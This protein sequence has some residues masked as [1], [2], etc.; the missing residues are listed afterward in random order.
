[1]IPE[2][3]LVGYFMVWRS[4]DYLLNPWGKIELVDLRNTTIEAGFTSDEQKK[5]QAIL[6]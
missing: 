6:I 1:M 4:Q 5:N 3:S 2:E